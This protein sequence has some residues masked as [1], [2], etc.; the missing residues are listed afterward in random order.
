MGFTFSFENFIWHFGK[1]QFH[2]DFDSLFQIFLKI[3]IFHLICKY[4]FLWHFKGKKGKNNYKWESVCQL[5]SARRVDIALMLAVDNWIMKWKETIL[6][7]MKMA[8]VFFMEINIQPDAKHGAS[9][10]D[11]IDFLRKQCKKTSF[12]DITLY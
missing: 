4:I 9:W 8:D 11:V 5:W 3:F 1:Y 10:G 12:Q 7:L 2:C 6:Q